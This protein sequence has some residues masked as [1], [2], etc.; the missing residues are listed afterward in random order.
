VDASFPGKNAGSCDFPPT[1]SFLPD[2]LTL[3][4]LRDAAAHCRGCPRYLDATQTVFGEGSGRATLIADLKL[5]ARQSR[6]AAV[7]A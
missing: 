3:P 1:E 5:A 4:A 7:T 2:K 6:R